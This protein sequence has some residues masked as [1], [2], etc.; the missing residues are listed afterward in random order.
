MDFSINSFL[1]LTFSPNESLRF[2]RTL[3]LGSARPRAPVRGRSSV[4][5]LSRRSSQV[6][7]PCEECRSLCVI[8]ERNSSYSQFRVLGPLEV[9]QGYPLDLRLLIIVNVLISIIY[10][11]IIKGTLMTY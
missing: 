2:G 8:M 3:T 1:L 7:R 9:S 11:S 4:P 10:N 6:R 5:T